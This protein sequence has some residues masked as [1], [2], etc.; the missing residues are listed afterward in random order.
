MTP[1]PGARAASTWSQPVDGDAGLELLGG[2]AGQA[3]RLDPVPGVA[4]EGGDDRPAQREPAE[5]GAVHP[6]EV[7]LDLA[8]PLAGDGDGGGGGRPRPTAGDRARAVARTTVEP[9]W[10]TRRA[11][12][13]TAGARRCA[14]RLRRRP[15]LAADLDPLGGAGSPAGPPPGG[16]RHR[17]GGRWPAA[18]P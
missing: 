2:R 14:A 13:A 9:T 3:E 17:G 15:A 6:P 4:L 8:A 5:V 1:V 18:R 10:K 12:E 11:R 16:G 7:A